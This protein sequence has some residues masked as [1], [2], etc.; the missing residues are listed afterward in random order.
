[1]A[2]QDATRKPAQAAARPAGS[3]RRFLRLAERTFHWILAPGLVLAI[4]I[5]EYGNLLP[6]AAGR[7]AAWTVTI[8]GLHKTVGL[9]MLFLVPGLAIALRPWRRRAVPVGRVGWAP[10]L[11]RVVFWG[12]MVGAFVIPVSGPILHGM[13]PGWGYAPVWWGLP[14]RVPFVPERLAA[15]PVTREFHIQ[16][17]WLFSALAITHVILAC[18]VWL[19]RRQ[20]SPRRWIRLRLPPLA[21][22]LAPLIGAALWVGLAIYSWRTA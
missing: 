12:L 15:S 14:N 8:Y 1:M 16:S 17:F 6:Y 2:N 13:G 21:H 10:V 5:S 4:G 9:A 11:D 22:R 19:M 20:S 3:G 18:R 7:E